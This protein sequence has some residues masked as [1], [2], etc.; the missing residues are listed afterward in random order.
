MVPEV[1]AA[2]TGYQ[3][4]FSGTGWRKARALPVPRLRSQ[5][6]ALAPPRLLRQL[7]L[8]GV[9][10][11]TLPK[12]ASAAAFPVLGWKSLRGLTADGAANIVELPHEF[13]GIR[14]RTSRWV[15]A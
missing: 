12:P 6:C 5:G 11:R 8:H 13:C 14:H 10:R 3:M 9:Y 7:L 2:Q 15:G 4:R 1:L